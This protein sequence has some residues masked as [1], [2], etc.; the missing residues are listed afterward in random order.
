MTPLFPRRAP[1][2]LLVM[3]LVG[4]ALLLGS[5]AA[6]ARSNDRD[7]PLDIHAGGLDG[8][9]AQHGD[10]QL[11]NVIITQGTLRIEAARATITR[12]HGA[13]THV[14]L[15]GEPALLQQEN[16]DGVLMKAQANRIQYDT[17][18]ET[19][20]LTGAVRIDQGRDVFRGA[21]VTYDTR[22]G[23]ISGD[24][25]AGGRIHLTIQPSNKPP[26]D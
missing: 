15:L 4:C 16:D 25:G 17:S 18:S 22:N 8:M 9:I 5:A 11:T 21:R 12:E 26:A 14:L 10:T 6:V 20:L 1:E 19:V 3:L 2:A 24:G 7:Q 13:V 23:R